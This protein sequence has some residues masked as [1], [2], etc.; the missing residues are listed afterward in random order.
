MGF[1]Q[2]VAKRCDACPRKVDVSGLCRECSVNPK[3]LSQWLRGKKRAKHTHANT[4]V[5]GG[6]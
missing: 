3:I 5:A 4:V 1:R 6:A 2:R